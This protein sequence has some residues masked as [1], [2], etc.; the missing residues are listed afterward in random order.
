LKITIKRA[1]TGLPVVVQKNGPFDARADDYFDGFGI[2]Q[3]LAKSI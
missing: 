2:K 1:Q 3:I